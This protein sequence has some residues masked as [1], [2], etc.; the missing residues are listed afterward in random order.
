VKP[1]TFFNIKT[2]LFLGDFTVIQVML[3]QMFRAL[4]P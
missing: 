3:T 1:L 2:S 4:Y